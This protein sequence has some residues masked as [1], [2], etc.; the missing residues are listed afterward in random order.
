MKK[1]LYKRPFVK[2]PLLSLLGII[3]IG[4]VIAVGLTGCDELLGGADKLL[5]GGDGT[6]PKTL[7][8][9]DI[10]GDQG[11]QPIQIGIFPAGTTPQQALTQTG[12]VAGADSSEGAVKLSGSTATAS[13]YVPSTGTG[14]TG[15]GTYDIYII[16]GGPNPTYYRVSS[17]SFTSASTRISANNFLPVDPNDNDN[18]DNN[19]NSGNDNSN[20]A[21]KKPT[22]LSSGATFDEIIAKLDEIIAYSGAPTDTKADAQELKDALKSQESSL[23]SAWSY[24][25]AAYLTPINGLIA[26][27][28]DNSDGG[29]QGGQPREGYHWI[30]FVLDDEGMVYERIE[31]QHGRIVTEIPAVEPTKDGYHFV[32]WVGETGSITEDTVFT[33]QWQEIIKF[34]DVIFMVD[35]AE[36][37]NQRI[38]NGGTA[39]PPVN[40]P[41]KTGWV[42]DGWEGTYTNVT[43]DITVTA[44]WKE[45]EYNVTFFAANG[46]YIEGSQQVVKHG[47]AATPPANPTRDG[48]VFDGWNA[49]YTNITSNIDIHPKWK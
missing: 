29:E 48:Y 12:I 38:M 17:V 32:G 16:V 11:Q 34:W 43:G 33:A 42:F 49:D 4:A 1:N 18:K 24:A 44:K 22:E 30:T 27:I 7:V 25:G 31:V 14:W 40:D 9:T 23:K 26:T 8:I 47:Q 20:N 21:G 41:T 35:G 2:K 36:V 3:A 39:T 28:P 37:S 46:G 6:D 45:A 13:L 10:P 15:S 19:G 5:G